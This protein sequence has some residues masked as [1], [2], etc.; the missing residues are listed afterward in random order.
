[1]VSKQKEAQRRLPKIF[2]V[3]HAR[4]RL[5]VAVALGVAVALF[6][7]AEWRLMLE[8]RRLALSLRCLLDRGAL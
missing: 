6:L 1:M 3:L 5:V 4:P 7:P 8:R 2:R